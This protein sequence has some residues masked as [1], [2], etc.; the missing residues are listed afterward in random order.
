MIRS[1]YLKKQ[2]K[3][4][5]H[6]SISQKDGATDKCSFREIQESKILLENGFVT[7]AIFESDAVTNFLPYCNI[8]LLRNTPRDRHCSDPPRLGAGNHGAVAQTFSLENKLGNLFNT[9]ENQS[10][11]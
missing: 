5:L 11:E 10:S 7:A 9:K 6:I 3:H 2:K 4:T 8:H 1:E